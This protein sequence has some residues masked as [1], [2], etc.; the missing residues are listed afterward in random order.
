MAQV[1]VRRPLRLSQIHRQERLRPLPRLDLRL[2]IDR[3]HDGVG[4]RGHRQPDDITNRRNAP[5]G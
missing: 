5:P 1:V 3:E 2:L 4:G